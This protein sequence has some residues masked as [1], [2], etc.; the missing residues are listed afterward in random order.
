MLRQNKFCPSIRVMGLLDEKSYASRPY[1][2]VVTSMPR[3]APSFS[4]RAI[5]V[6]HRANVYNV[7][8]PFRLYD[9]FAAVKR[10]RIEHNGIDAPV[11][12][13]ACDANV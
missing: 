3:P 1:L 6:A 8:V 12:A 13:C 10:I 7:V 5:E 4:I 9:I 2:L 11:S